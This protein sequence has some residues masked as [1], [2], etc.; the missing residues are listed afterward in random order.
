MFLC[1]NHF[2]YVNWVS[3]EDEYQDLRKDISAEADLTYE[4]VGKPDEPQLWFY[5]STSGQAP[6]VSLI[7][8]DLY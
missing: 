7:P 2:E 8:Q 6:G 4:E 5:C 1:N 3:D